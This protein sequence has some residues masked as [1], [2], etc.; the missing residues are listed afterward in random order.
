MLEGGMTVNDVAVS[1][2]VHRT[3]IWR[4][5]QRFRTTGT[6]KDR[7]RSGR[8]KR[9][10]PRK[11]RYIRIASPR[12]RFLPATRIVD[13]VRR[14]TGVRNK[15]KACRFKSCRPHKGMELTVHHKRQ[16]HAWTNQQLRRHWRT[17]L[18]SDESRFTLKFADG[19]IRVWRRTDEQFAAACV[20]LVDHFI[21]NWLVLWGGVHYAG[22]TNVIVI[23]QTLNAQRYC[24]DMY[25]PLR[26]PSC[27]ETIVC[28]SAEQCSVTH[29]SSLHESFTGQQY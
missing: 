25:S 21:G 22:K 17:V 26:C 29:R 18:F 8:P 19:R 28:L 27:T 11:E 16:Q 6:V 14:S 3:T 7:P 20:M 13:R 12:D 15:L 24:N 9:L 4:L 5:A 23:R 2:G 1:F 10:T